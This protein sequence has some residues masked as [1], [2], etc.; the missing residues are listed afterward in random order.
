MDV[1]KRFGPATQAWFRERFER[2][3]PV[4]E[5]GWPRIAAGEHTL[6]LAPT[7][8]GKTLAAFLA[9]LDRLCHE[10]TPR[11]AGVRV[12]YLSPL[13][14]LAYDVERNLAQPLA[15]I[16]RH[17]AAL[18]TPLQLP[19][20]DLRSGD[21]PAAERRRQARQPG[22]ILITTPESLFLILGSAQ[23]ETLRHVDTVI[24]DEIHVMAGSK[25]GVHLA[26][27]LERLERLCPRPPQRLGLS[28]TVRPV[29]EVA[30][31]LA[32]GRPV[33]V[34]DAVGRPSLELS[35]VVPVEDMS[36]PPEPA[37]RARPARP[38]PPREGPLGAGPE[39]RSLWPSLVP[40]MLD[41]ILGRRS[42]IVFTNSRQLC[43]RLC[44]RINEAW[45]ERRP[46]GGVEPLVRAHHG[47]VSREQRVEMEQAL[48]EGRLRGIV[49]TSS[50]ELGIDMGAVDLVLQVEAPDTVARGLQRVGRAGHGLGEVSRALMLPKHRGDLLHSAACAREMLRGEI[51]DIHGPRN[52]L[53]V[54]AQQVVAACAVE[55]LSVDEL[56]ALARATQ[57]YADL[58]RAALLGVLE[59]LAGSYLVPELSDLRPRVVWDRERDRVRTRD[60]ARRIVLLNAGTIPDRGAFA[61]RLLGGGPRLG[62]LDEE[63]VH[64]SRP[65]QT[66][67]LGAST[68]RIREIGRDAV[69]VEPAPG[70][71]ARLPFW[72]GAGPGRSVALGRAQGRLL[73]ELVAAPPAVAEALLERD[74]HLDALARRNLLAFVAQQQASTGV[75]PDDRTVVVERFRD[76]L[77]DWRVCVLSPWGGRVHAPWALAVEA[78]LARRL[79]FEPQVLYGDD[80]IVMRFADADRLP[81]LDSLLPDPEEVDELVLERL[82]GSSLFAARFREA[83]ARALLLDRRAPGRRSPL[84]AQRLRAQTLLAVVRRF[85]SFPIVAEV[86]RELLQ[87]VFDLPALRE[88]LRALRSR[89]VRVHEVETPQASPFARSL[90][91]TFVA[92]HL[93]DGDLPAAERKAQALALDRGL[94]AELLGQEGL[95]ELLDPAVLREVEAELQGLAPAHPVRGP[96]ALHDLL[97]RVGD[98]SEAELADRC[99]AAPG[100]WLATLQQ[101]GRATL[102]QVGGDQRWI[103][104]GDRALYAAALGWAGALPGAASAEGPLGAGGASGDPLA[105][106]LRRW[107]RTHG[108]FVSQTIAQRWGLARAPLDAALGRLLAQG[109]LVRGELS[110][111]RQGLE[112]CDA[113]VLRRLRGRSLARLR[114][115]VEAVDPF[116]FARFS[117][118]WQGIGEARPLEQSLPAALRA[119]EGLPLPWSELESR[120]LPAR[121]PGLRP[122]H[123][124]ELG[125]RG[126]LVWLGC[127]ALGLRDGKV[128]LLRRASLASLSPRLPAEPPEDPLQAAILRELGRRGACFASELQAA[129][130]LPRQDE[131][132]AALW[133]LVWQGRISNDTFAPLR[134]LRGGPRRGQA[135]GGRWWCLEG[136]LAGPAPPAPTAQALER[137]QL[138]LERHGILSAAQVAAEE[139]PGGFSGLYPILRSLEEA[140][141]VRRGWFVDGLAGA[142][143]ALP[144]ALERLRALRDAPGAAEEPVALA[145]CDPA[146]PWGAAL[147]WPALSDPAGPAPRRSPGATLVLLGGR[148][149][150]LLDGRGRS[151]STFAAC[152]EGSFERAL[153][154][155]LAGGAPGR[156]AALILER[157]DGRPARSS[158]WAAT[159]LRLGFH[160]EPG[161]LAWG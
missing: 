77:G 30:G 103:A 131:L 29:A 19:A 22:E 72:K 138:L 140:G 31:F 123:L 146:Q 96:D 107:A 135:A 9:C 12:L 151:L 36:H 68:W 43:E 144:G 100:A 35:V 102:L 148:P 24:V 8:A 157:I 15:G 34:V 28:A 119:L 133:A 130:G 101:Q 110:P 158:P 94:L 104:A 92:G 3:S 91:F 46:E 52:C 128:A 137:A 38:G 82:G 64:E 47:S 70:E 65:G 122:R 56:L 136:A 76:E 121:V 87:D 16:A 145:A 134:A 81:D 88:L 118:Q 126:E 40:L 26:L 39:L 154:A 45:E 2:V 125:A 60:D 108:P 59:M 132:H 71:P 115:Q 93:Y 127:G 159:L 120:I 49:A 6:L 109:A 155:L 48:K 78:L 112:W 139:V 161:R 111:G 85:P 74:C 147:P 7:G 129:C 142:Q 113:E 80:G 66:F 5:Q 153:P 23:R 143:F 41:Q 27:S 156:R 11:P 57:P 25:R 58:S 54:L 18:G 50:L 33:A 44:Q 14:A 116:T 99:S 37:P 152:D 86:S 63:M 67:I 89:S 21:T 42:T 150:L 17:A 20:V 106:L 84:W 114:A 149:Q 32:G 105:D 90:V 13:K 1:L 98:L 69:L 141:R 55:E 124:D 97:R 73:R 53:D 62:E 160:E 95:R 75:L 79:G 61:V 117:P 51:E 4:Q 10:A 83:A